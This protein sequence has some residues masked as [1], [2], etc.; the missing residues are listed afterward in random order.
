MAPS[1]T[2]RDLP[3]REEGN[4]PAMPAVLGAG[5][6]AGVGALLGASVGAAENVG[7]AE[8]KHCMDRPCTSTHA[9]C[10]TLRRLAVR[11]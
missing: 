7:A 11:A 1:G 4:A 10:A 2:P 6:P 3:R 8:D 9:Q 5:V